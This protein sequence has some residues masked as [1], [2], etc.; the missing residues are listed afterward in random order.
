[1][2]RILFLIFIIISL[3][4]YCQ[5]EQ[6]T[7]EWILSKIEKYGNKSTIYGNV[8]V[9]YVNHYTGEVSLYYNNSW[10][11]SVCVFNINDID[12][13]SKFIPPVAYTRSNTVKRIADNKTIYSS[14]APIDIDW[15]AEENL[16][17]RMQTAIERLVQLKRESIKNEAF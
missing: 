13:C 5:S 1:M 8:S 3:Q 15:T 11:K 4:S 17:A 7:K 14:I 9:N 16:S 10:G 6:V 2:K 12:S